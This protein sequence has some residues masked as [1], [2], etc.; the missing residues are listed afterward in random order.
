VKARSRAEEGIAFICG[1]LRRPSL[2]GCAR[3]QKSSVEKALLK[4]AG[5]L[6]RIAGLERYAF[7]SGMRQDLQYQGAGSRIIY[8]KP[9]L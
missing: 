4:R 6:V 8:L 5:R 2:S 9:E 7:G 3:L 1:S